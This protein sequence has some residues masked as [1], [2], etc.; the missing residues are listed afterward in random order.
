MPSATLRAFAL[1]CTLKPSPAP[2]SSELMINELLA[3]LSEHD[4]ESELVRV[5][6]HEVR[7]G[8]SSDEGGGDEWPAL[9]EKILAADIFVLGT[10]IWLGNP[11]SICRRVLERLDAMLGETDDQGRMIAFDRV[12]CTTVVG[13]EDGAHAVFAQVAQ[14][15]SDIGF[16]VPA[17]GSAYW[18]GEAMGSTDFNDLETVPEPVTQSL[19]T[20][21]ANAAHLARLLRGDGYPV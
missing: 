5:V 13:N 14:A 7:P 2:S 21:A 6:D 8:V 15:L 4:V 3:A 20:L 12:A 16:T 1:N 17:S 10:P 9:R 11:S 19:Q 18:T